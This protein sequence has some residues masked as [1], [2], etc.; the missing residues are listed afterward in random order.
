MPPAAAVE[1]DTILGGNES[2][3]GGMD[4]KVRATFA[5]SSE[6]H[7]L[8]WKAALAIAVPG[9]ENGMPPD[10]LRR[11]GLSPLALDRVL[12]RQ[13]LETFVHFMEA[14][15]DGHRF[16]LAYLRKHWDTHMHNG[17]TFALDVVR[18]RYLILCS[19]NLGSPEF[20]ELL[21]LYNFKNARLE[22]KTAAPRTTFAMD[23]TK[24]YAL[25]RGPA[26]YSRDACYEI[27]GY[28]TL[29]SWHHLRVTP[30]PPPH[31]PASAVVEPI[32]GLYLSV[33]NTFMRHT[34][35]DDAPATGPAIID[36]K[37]ALQMRRL[38]IIEELRLAPLPCYAS[39]DILDLT[40]LPTTT[41]GDGNILRD[42]AAIC[43]TFIFYSSGDS[44]VS[45]RLHDM[46][47]D[48][49]NITLFVNREKHPRSVGRRPAPSASLKI[50]PG[51]N[52]QV[53]PS[54][55]LPQLLYCKERK[56]G[57]E[58]LK[59]PQEHVPRGDW[60][61]SFDLADGYY[62][63]DIHEVDRDFFTS[64]YRGT[65]YRLAGLPMGWHWSNY[66]FCKRTEVFVQHLFAPEPPA[67]SDPAGP[68]PARPALAKQ[69]TLR[70][71]HNTR[72]RGGAAAALH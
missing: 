1:E 66:Y 39:I 5:P 60:I 15:V 35:R 8:D 59:Q 18:G 51:T 22:R 13:R 24:A 47:V 65:L 12:E 56:L 41:T 52:N 63:L 4:Q 48:A 55:R 67:S 58:T 46:A 43:S 30:G 45:C 23:V 72:W 37:R 62:T 32:S 38:K 61:V 7:Y 71:L 27:N 28:N 3:A 36:M 2:R 26:R 70:Y 19:E 17:D 11:L 44:G 29:P 69:L 49:H 50:E 9:F 57:Y 33:I 21:E 10:N 25:S 53:A 40:A 42:G 68:S 14:V 54:H 6:P 31:Y 16:R 34:G 20:T 64:D